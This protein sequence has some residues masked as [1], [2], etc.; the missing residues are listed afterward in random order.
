M[1]LQMVEWNVDKTDWAPVILLVT[2]G[3]G[4]FANAAFAFG[5]LL[6]S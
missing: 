6:F 4:A 1:K 3:F 5:E 2:L